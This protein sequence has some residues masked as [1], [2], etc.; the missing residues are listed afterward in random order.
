[1][2]SR[3]ANTVTSHPVPPATSTSPSPEPEPEPGGQQDVN[4]M[5][6]DV[7]PLEP[8]LVN[9][10]VRLDVDEPVRAQ[11]AN[12]ESREPMG[13]GAEDEV[14]AR[15]IG[16]TTRGRVDDLFEDEEDKAEEEEP[17]FERLGKW[18]EDEKTDE[19][20]KIRRR[21]KRKRRKTL[22]DEE[23]VGPCSPLPDEDNEFPLDLDHDPGTP[24]PDDEPPPPPDEK[25]S[26]THRKGEEL[27]PL[28]VELG[29][30]STVTNVQATPLANL[31]NPYHPFRSK[32][33]WDIAVWAKI[34]GIGSN[35]FTDILK[36]GGFIDTLC[37][38]FKTARDLH[39]IMDKGQPGRPDFVP[40]SFEHGGEKLELYMRDSLEVVKELFRRPDLATALV[41]APE[42]HYVLEAEVETRS[43]WDMHTAKWWWTMQSRIERH[44]PGTTIIPLIISSDTTQL[45]PFRNRAAYPV[46]ITIRNIPKELWHKTSLQA[47]LL[48]G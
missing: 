33:N 17:G 21:R 25:L 23:G 38:Q 30:R 32:T 7:Q 42:I 24:P 9:A 35:A 28:A 27:Y 16:K 44:K 37:L 47:Q 4:T 39:G 31:N 29:S 11:D 43:C 41:S 3:Q 26:H 12:R 13:W 46:Y 20:G 2:A 22:P 36:I 14:R 15:R 6:V 5:D 40:Q 18:D 10:D 19:A 45:T 8:L 1:M 48:V 34:H